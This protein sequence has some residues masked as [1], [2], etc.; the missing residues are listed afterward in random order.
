MKYYKSLG[1]KYINYLTNSMW[2]HTRFFKE[3]V[4][5]FLLS[6]AKKFFKPK[7]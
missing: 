1:Y 7:H 6:H 3:K 2:V 5:Q 4:S